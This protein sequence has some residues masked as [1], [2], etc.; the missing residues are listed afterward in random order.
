MTLSVLRA[1]LALSIIGDIVSVNG[2]P[3]VT[4]LPGVLLRPLAAMICGNAS[5][6]CFRHGYVR[7]CS[8]ANLP[9]E[10]RPH[11]LPTPML[12]AAHDPTI[13][14]GP[15]EDWIVFRA[16]RPAPSW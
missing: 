15:L 11:S 13:L 6:R 10:A 5:T 14:P 12:R 1:C 3:N 8:N 7:R 2:V 4:I 9:S 16:M